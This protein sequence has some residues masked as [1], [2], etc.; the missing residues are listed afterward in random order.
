MK[1]ADRALD[2][3]SRLEAIGI[4]LLIDDFGSGYSNLE[5][6]SYIPVD[7]IKIDKS[8]IDRGLAED[9]QDTVI[10][11]IIRM[12]KDLDKITVAEGVETADQLQKLEA[13]GCD[14]IQ[15]YY[16]D[17]PLTSEDALELIQKPKYDK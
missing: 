3:F 16:F 5:Y 12:S 17:R 6:L 10:R 13:L 1:N 14:E 2:L 8:L 11:E 7:Y 9:G 15:G 4:K